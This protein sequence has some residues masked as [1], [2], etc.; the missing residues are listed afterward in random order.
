MSIFKYFL[1]MLLT[2]FVYAL[3]GL[4]IS[5]FLSLFINPGIIY[6]VFGE[7][8]GIYILYCTYSFYGFIRSTRALAN[9]EQM[10]AA[11]GIDVE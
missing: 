4:G 7:L 5:T 2:I 9:Y 8:I 3:L 6:V 11:G 1:R 10:Q